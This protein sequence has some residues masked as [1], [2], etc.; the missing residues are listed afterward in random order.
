[1]S[2][3]YPPLTPELSDFINRHK[4][5]LYIA[6]GGRFYTTAESNS[7]ILQSIIEVINKKMVDGVVWALAQTSKNDFPFTL[8]LSD[9]LRVHTAS[10]LNNEHPHIH[11]TGFAPQFAVLNHTNTKLFLS[12]GGAGSTHESLFTGTPMLV[13]PIGGD[14]MGNAQKLQTAGIALTLNKFNLEVDDIVNK[15]NILLNDEDIKNNVERMKFLAK[16]S[17]KRKYKAA[18]LIEYISYRS[19]L[20]KGSNQE[21][22]EFIPANTKMGFIRGNNYDVYGVILGLVLGIIVGILRIIFKLFRFI[23]PSSNQKPKRE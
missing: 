16:I 20:N 18:D 13:L 22:N 2:K 21:L 15:I 11:I 10:I 12:H 9:G 4:R 14:Q 19:D 3:E 1:M 23:V 8:S 6:F 17:S 5:V 7:K